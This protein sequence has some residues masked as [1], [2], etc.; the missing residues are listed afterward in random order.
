MRSLRCRWLSLGLAMERG[1]PLYQHF[2]A[3][4]GAGPSAKC[5]S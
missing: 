5:R 3:M 1:M 4:L 2:A